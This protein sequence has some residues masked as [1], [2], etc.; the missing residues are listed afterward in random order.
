MTPAG[1]RQVGT[2]GNL[3]IAYMRADLDRQKLTSGIFQEIL[4]YILTP[5]CYFHSH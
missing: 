3:P 5:D 4:K 2:T 1:M